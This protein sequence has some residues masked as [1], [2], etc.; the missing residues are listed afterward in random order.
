M[1]EKTNQ[2]ENRQNAEKEEFS[3][4]Q[5]P[6][7]KE[8]VREEKDNQKAQKESKKE[9]SSEKYTIKYNGNLIEMTIDELKAN[10]QKG[11]NYDRVKAQ[12]DMLAQREGLSGVYLEF[13]EAYPEVNPLSIPQEVWDAANREGNLLSAYRA[14][15][16]RQLKAKITAMEQNLKNKKSAIG[17]AGTSGDAGHMDPFLAG[18]LGK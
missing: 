11:L 1:F 3:D 12:R 6:A 17:S 5:A 4:M 8:N 15:E 2:T 16:N 18:L 14:F 13:L 9:K 7:Q 10:A